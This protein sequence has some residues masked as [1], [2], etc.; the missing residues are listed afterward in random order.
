MSQGNKNS[1]KSQ[2]RHEVTTNNLNLQ[3]LSDNAAATVVAGNKGP[4]TVTDAGSIKSAFDFAKTVDASGKA[5]IDKVLGLAGDLWSSSMNQNQK[6]IQEVKN[7]YQD[8]KVVDSQYLV[9]TGLIVTALVGIKVFG[10]K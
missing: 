10:G 7:A 3:G 5:T 6:V 4:V 9:I 8:A 1:S 2:T